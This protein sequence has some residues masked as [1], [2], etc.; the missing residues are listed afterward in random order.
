MGIHVW[1]AEVENGTQGL[2][3]LSFQITVLMAK[4]LYQ[5]F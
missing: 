3:N 5:L 1:S 4:L 2:A